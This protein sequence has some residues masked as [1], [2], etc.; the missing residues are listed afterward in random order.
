MLRKKISELT[1]DEMNWMD[2]LAVNYILAQSDGFQSGYAQAVSDL[3]EYISDYWDGSDDKPQKSLLDTLVDLGVKLSRRK[4]V[5]EDNL[6]RAKEE[7][8]EAYYGWTFKRSDEPFARPVKLF[9]KEFASDKVDRNEGQETEHTSGCEEMDPVDDEK[10]N[11]QIEP[12]SVQ[13]EQE[14][15]QTEQEDAQN[16]HE[17]EHTAA[18]EEDGPQDE[19]TEA[20]HQ[21]N[22]LGKWADYKGKALSTLEQNL[23]IKGMTEEDYSL[24]QIASV[25]RLSQPTICNRKKKLREAGELA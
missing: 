4:G 11:I 19:E 5:A 25:V 16:Y 24:S 1:I 23:I 22:R 18:D 3:T 13:T 2:T 8:Y 7:G 20:P 15:A 14:D 21:K 12:E 17:I 10:E 6:R 9:T